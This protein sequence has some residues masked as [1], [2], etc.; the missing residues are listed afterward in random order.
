MEKIRELEKR[1]QRLEDRIRFL[2]TLTESLSDGHPFYYLA[3]ESELTHA[4]V[5]A[6]YDL[7]EEVLTSIMENKPVMHHAEFEQRIYKIV[8]SH[9]GDYH[10]AESIV[11]TLN[12]EGNQ[13]KKVYEHMKK[14]GM[15][16]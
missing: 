4:Q 15:N 12:R 3:L 9:K 10:F 2:V 1:V 5:T 6:I 16:I 14:S 8:P 7:M 11:S 13:W